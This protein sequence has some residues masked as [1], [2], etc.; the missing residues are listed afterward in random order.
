MNSLPDLAH[1]ILDRGQ[2]GSF[3]CPPVRWAKPPGAQEQEEWHGPQKPSSLSLPELQPL[4]I[5][6]SHPDSSGSGWAPRFLRA[7]TF[8][9]RKCEATVG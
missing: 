7:G 5:T 9:T 3:P 1:I 4:F 8:H 2:W 6:L